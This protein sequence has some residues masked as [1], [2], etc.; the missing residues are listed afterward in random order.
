M[1]WEE[2]Y[3]L[4]S[5]T[6]SNQ[7]L[8]MIQL[9]KI[10]FYLLAIVLVFF[11][12]CDSEDPEMENDEEVITDV[13]LNFTE[14]DA[15]GN[16]AGLSF[17]FSAS[18]PQGIEVG[19]S[20]I[21]ETVTLDRAKSYSMTISV[22]NSIENEDISEEIEEEADEHQFYFLGSGFVGSS[23]PMTYEYN[24]PSGELVGLEGIITVAGTLPFNN[25]QMRVILRHD[26][27]KNYPGADNPNFENFVEAGG[28][29]DLD[30]TF[31]VTFN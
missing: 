14:L 29:S 12:S 25:A 16:P 11:S 5:I 1:I 27:D 18:D 21:I 30:I 4:K 10:P 20:P 24:D 6:N 23:A 31:P 7:L 9:K 2:T 22:L 15:S 26:L 8:L 3:Y 13:T 28:S 19:N 17:S